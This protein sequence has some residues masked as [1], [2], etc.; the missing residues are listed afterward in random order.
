MHISADDFL[1][2]ASPEPT[3]RGGNGETW[4]AWNPSLLR[5]LKPLTCGSNLKASRAACHFLSPPPVGSQGSSDAAVPGGSPSLTQDTAQHLTQASRSLIAYKRERGGGKGK[6]E[7][8]GDGHCCGVGQLLIDWVRSRKL[9]L[10]P[11]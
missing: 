7:R 1:P 6:S 2:G 11:S 8:G 9:A 5:F 10:L 4:Q 3:H